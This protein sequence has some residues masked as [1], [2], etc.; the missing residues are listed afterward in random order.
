MNTGL[1]S[2]DN[3]DN[4]GRRY[5]RCLVDER[6]SATSLTLVLLPGRIA[7]WQYIFKRPSS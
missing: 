5:T 3:D 6:G 4:E 1:L 7:V 2:P